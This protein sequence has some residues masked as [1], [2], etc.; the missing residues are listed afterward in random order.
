MNYTRRIIHAQTVLP[1]EIL[2]KLKEKTGEKST[3]D[4]IYKAIEHYLICPYTHE[5]LLDKK[6]EEYLKKK[7]KIK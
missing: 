7:E 2:E 1:I 6:L 3:K 5:D 4:A